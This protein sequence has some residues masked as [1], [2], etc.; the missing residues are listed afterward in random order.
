MS[1]LQ[2]QISGICLLFVCCTAA[3][4]PARA[5][6]VFRDSDD[7]A[8]VVRY[9]LPGGPAQLAG[10]ASGDQIL[11]V[12]SVRC[13][14]RREFLHELRRVADS[15]ACPPL[16]V[17]RGSREVGLGCIGQA[18]ESVS[19]E[20]LLRL[21]DSAAPVVTF[22]G[23]GGYIVGGSVEFGRPLLSLVESRL[24]GGA[25]VSDFTYCVVLVSE[26]RQRCGGVEVL[27]QY[28][29][30]GTLSVILRPLSPSGTS[31]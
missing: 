26:Q 28:P 25:R 19:A 24:D 13:S 27:E 29:D 23:H 22:V 20:A 14:T 7:E 31:D 12:G 5:G 2:C 10:L 11:Q 21:A 9:V 30:A 3:R 15:G 17:R 8:P 18:G 1:S 16:L 6:L 4:E